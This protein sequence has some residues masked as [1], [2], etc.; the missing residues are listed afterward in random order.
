MNANQDEGNKWW[1]QTKLKS[2]QCEYKVNTQQIHV[3]K[4]NPYSGDSKY[5]LMQDSGDC[6]PIL[7]IQAYI[8]EAHMFFFVVEVHTN[9]VHVI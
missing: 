9:N 2:N 3:T 6:N 8:Q 1:T 4:Q 7:N 5:I